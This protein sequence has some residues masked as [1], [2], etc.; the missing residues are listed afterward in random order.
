MTPLPM[1][2]KEAACGA[3]FSLNNQQVTV[4]S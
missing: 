3:P 1:S 4:E 2:T